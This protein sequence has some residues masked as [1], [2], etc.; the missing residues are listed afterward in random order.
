[1]ATE[2]IRPIAAI[3]G[4]PPGVA[5]HLSR[6]GSADAGQGIRQAYGH[7]IHWIFRGL[8]DGE[9]RRLRI[10]QLVVICLVAGQR[11]CRGGVARARVGVIACNGHSYVDDVIVHC[12]RGGGRLPV[13]S[14]LIAG[15]RSSYSFDFHRCTGVVGLLFVIHILRKDINAVIRSPCFIGIS[16]RQSECACACC[17]P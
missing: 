4:M 6:H 11:A 9:G 8:A 3:A 7:V 2:K 17:G 16:I 13:I 10:R 5:G 1:M 12:R 15:S 14:T